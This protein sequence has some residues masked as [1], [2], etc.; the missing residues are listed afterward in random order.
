MESNIG[1]RTRIF[2]S[3]M[4]IEENYKNW[5]MLC[6]SDRPLVPFIGAGISA[7]CYYT[8]DSLL[9]KVVRENFSK[10][11]SKV[12]VEAL[13]CWE[14][15]PD[16]EKEDLQDFR[17]MEEIAEYIFDDD[18]EDF[19][20]C[21]NRFFLKKDADKQKDSNR[22]FE[23]LH[24]YLGGYGVKARQEAV[25]SLYDAF[26]I[27][28]MKQA[29]NIPEYQHFFP[30]LFP[31]L[32]V[33]TN[34][35]K[36]LEYCYPSI[37]SYSYSDLG[38]K[39]AIDEKKESWLCR[40]IEE[41]LAQMEARLEGVD[42]AAGIAV[43]NVPM[44]LKVHGSIEQAS[45]IALSR[46]R[47]DEVYQGKMPEIFGKI[48][49]RSSLLFMGC[50][51][52]EDRILDVL[53]EQKA[54]AE[55]DDDYGFQHFVFY[56]EPENPDD[57]KKKR[58]HLAEYGI[59]P[60]FYNKDVLKDV[61]PELSDDDVKNYHDDCLGILLENLLRRKRHYHQ[62][63][64]LLGG[65]SQ[66]IPLEMSSSM[67]S[68][69]RIVTINESSQYVHME[70]AS[71]IWELLKS[72]AEC[73]LIAVTGDT[74]SGKSLFCQNIQ[75]LNRNPKDVM[76]FFYIPLED[77]K[78]W[79]EFCIQIYQ[80]LNIITSE[81]GKPEDWKKVAEQVEQ[82]CS[83]YWRS[84]L[85]LDHLDDLK[86]DSIYP[87]QWEAIKA[88]LNYWKE[89][90][91]RVIF[92]I[93]EYPKGISCYTWHIGSLKIDEAEKVFFSACT[94]RQYG[95]S[96]LL[97][98]SVL[99]ELFNRQT[100][101]PASAY[102][103]GQ[104][105][106]SKNDL[107][108]LL[109][110]W[111]SCH[112][113]GDGGVQTLS[114]L[115]W[116]H[117]LDEHQWSDKD[118]RERQ[119][120]EENILWIW[121]ILGSYPGIFPK[122]FFD[123][124]WSD[125]SEYK[126]K[127]LSRKT[128][129][130]M[131]N[132]GLCEETIDEKYGFLLDNMFKCARE[133][134]ET[135]KSNDSKYEQFNF[136]DDIEL[137]GLESFFGYTM[138]KY[139]GDLREHTL[140]ELKEKRE[141]ARSGTET[142]V[143]AI[144][145]PSEEI[146]NILEAVGKEIEN[147]EKRKCHKALNLVLHYEIRT[148]IRFLLTQLSRRTDAEKGTKTR[149]DI[150]KIGYCFSHYYHYV[151]SHAF[152][153][154]QKLIEIA[155]NS[156]R[157]YGET[158]IS[159]GFALY[160]VANLYKVMGDVHRLLGHKEHAI[161]FYTATS[162]KCDEQMLR[163]FTASDDNRSYQE[164]LRIKAAV[165][166]TAN[167]YG[168]GGNTKENKTEKFYERIEKEWGKI[169]KLYDYIGDEWGKAYYNQR[170][171]ELF[172]SIEP[173]PP[174]DEKNRV[175]RFGYVRKCYNE[176]AKHYGNEADMTGL[177]YIL[178]C[179]GDLLGEYRD[180][181]EDKNFLLQK[182]ENGEAAYYQIVTQSSEDE[183]NYKD[184][185]Y[186]AANCYAQ[187]FILYRRHINW[188]GFANVLQGMG[189]LLRYHFLDRQKVAEPHE[190]EKM[191]MLYKSAEECYRWLGDAR[192][193]ADTLDYAGHGYKENGGDVGEYM[194]LGKWIESKEIWRKQENNAKAKKTA[195]EISMLRKKISDARK[196]KA[197]AQKQVEAPGQEDKK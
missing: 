187:A 24:R 70:K 38:E 51:L 25:N 139:N 81:I 62:P 71:Q 169:G 15:K 138:D 37:F 189:N 120:I 146:L 158:D 167:Y 104:Y 137:N 88:M 105:A 2:K 52:R 1:V 186:A 99:D 116:N 177:A 178:K 109:E 43:P 193:L 118:T 18:E 97:E 21:K 14:D 17:W 60:I 130:F 124:I 78:T 12:V 132:A 77:C 145:D 92:T 33:T 168:P 194:A 140:K 83:G 7:W 57:M 161:E 79:N 63:F 164:S 134:S 9:E 31:D 102:L 153:L 69:A 113:P 80:N 185:I 136:A 10:E 111:E 149:I 162:R 84:V 151:P 160:E 127:D 106:D 41:K 174:K 11:C 182:V 40:V 156:T 13:K 191:K 65:K 196:P 73:P 98:R 121:G 56:P 35:D 165:L 75:K 115:M 181:F 87:G 64:E 141:K 122:A 59:Y 171:G 32:L 135:L 180:V 20:N 150:A 128:L 67:K 55:K 133:F 30:R 184:A 154:V 53:K 142:E 163:A 36:A 27:E 188:R 93:H 28:R 82:R 34:Y 94:S 3:L 91:T 26:S 46:A 131:K 74:G 108:T 49:R 90:Q 103:L 86:D 76:Q 179:M 143:L 152:P 85:I 155:E 100:F 22:I 147:D 126:K 61:L 101:Q 95:N 117:L 110:E 173:S 197:E 72:N 96:S 47:Y 195:E 8:W 58:E 114:R 125:E 66:F 112:L 183:K 119:N 42:R 190:Y 123:C 166:L 176:A 6:S 68:A 129:I 192:G 4:E 54:E 19:K 172:S 170:K 50:G 107:A 29:G 5:E 144:M 39:N 159:N 45:N 157:D 23:N 48:C 89:H 44:L 148:V 16:I 175:I